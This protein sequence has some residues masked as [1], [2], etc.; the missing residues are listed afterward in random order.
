[1]K[2]HLF[3][4]CTVSG[5]ADRTCRRRARQGDGDSDGDG[6]GSMVV[7]KNAFTVDKKFNLVF[8]RFVIYWNVLHFPRAIGSSRAIQEAE[9]VGGEGVRE[10]R[11]SLLDTLFFC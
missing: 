2:T 7:R 6:G 1:M 10:R 4:I 11:K 8:C 3:T 5:H 9:R